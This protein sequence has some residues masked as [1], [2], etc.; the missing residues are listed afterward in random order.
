M[1]SVFLPFWMM[2]HIRKDFRVSQKQ[3]HGDALIFTVWP[4]HAIIQS[5]GDTMKVKTFSL[6]VLIIGI[7]ALLIGLDLP[8]LLYAVNTPNGIIGGAGLPTYRLYLDG[9]PVCLLLWGGVLT[10]TGLFCLIFSKTV[11]KHCGIRTSAVALSLS[12]V[13]AV[14]LVC[15]LM[16]IVFATFGEV[17]RHPISYPC[18]VIG[19]L[20]AFVTFVVLVI[21]Y[22]G[23]RKNNPTILGIVLDVFMSIA[24]LPAFFY[25]LSLIESL[26]S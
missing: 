19:G 5:R 13:G 18:S 11:K 10:V 25:T 1:L 3:K 12:A 6:I 16:W 20:L 21:V 22:F 4:Y 26:I 9:V 14:G 7:L 8:M 15:F 24:Y 2:L 17:S 23:F